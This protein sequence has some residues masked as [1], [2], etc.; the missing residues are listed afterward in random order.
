MLYAAWAYTN[1]N[2]NLIFGFD[3]NIEKGLGNGYD[4]PTAVWPRTISNETFLYFLNLGS[5]SV[6]FIN[7]IFIYT[8]QLNYQLKSSSTNNGPDA[9]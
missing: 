9:K 8:T 4:R 7:F 6:R 1:V 2:T 5:G 3:L